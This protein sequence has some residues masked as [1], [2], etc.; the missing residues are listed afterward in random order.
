MRN[1]IRSELLINREDESKSLVSTIK[2]TN[3]TQV[4][5]LYST[6]GIGKSSLSA[7][8][9]N[10]LDLD[11]NFSVIRAK[12]LPQNSQVLA[13]EGA[14]MSLIFE[15][16]YNTFILKHKKD[17]K[18][19]YRK[20]LS[21]NYYI[22]HCKNEVVKQAIKETIFKQIYSDFSRSTALKLIFFYTF[23]RIFKIGEFNYIYYLNNNGQ[24][25]RVVKN[26]YLKYIFSKTKILFNIDNIQNI[27]SIS[28][29]Y[30]IDW[31]S[32]SK[33]QNST[34][35]LEYTISKSFSME[36]MM[37]LTEYFK[38]A[39][40][41]IIIQPIKKMDENHA[42]YALQKFTN[43][44]YSQ[45]FK[46]K[47]FSYFTKQSCGNIRKLFD[48]GINYSDEENQD[49]YDPTYENILS[50]NNDCKYILSIIIAFNGSID[51]TILMILLER[52]TEIM[53]DIPQ[54]LL[55][56]L[57]YEYKLVER[58]NNIIE[59]QHASIIDSWI[60]H[61]K[62]FLLFDGIAYRK[63]SDLL[64]EIMNNKMYEQLSSGQVFT[65]L[66]HLYIKNE[67][68]RIYEL[69]DVL[70]EQI[71]ESVSARNAW[72]ILEEL[73]RYT[74]NNLNDYANLYY[75]I[76]FIC[77]DCELFK[78]GFNC[79]Q[80]WEKNTNLNSNFLIFKCLFMLGLDKHSEC[81]QYIK[82]LDGMPESSPSFQLSLLLINIVNYRSLNQKEEC[83][84]ISNLIESEK[85]YSN[86]PEYGYY[87]RLKAIFLPRDKGLKTIN[88]SIKFFELNNQLLQSSKSRITVAFYYAII[89]ELDTAYNH[90]TLA[91]NNLPNKYI[92]QYMIL[93]NKSAIDLLAGR[94]GNEVWENLDRAELS[95]TMPFDHLSI[96]NNK[97]VWCLAN[98]D[99]NN[100]ELII[101]KI[102]R[103]FKFEEDKH[104]RSFMYYNMH[105][106]YKALGN[107]YLTQIYYD[108]A[109][110]IR[111]FCT[112]LNAR[113]EN[114]STPD[115]TNFLLS[116]PWHVC[117]VSYWRFDPLS[118]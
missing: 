16:A 103:Y 12:T 50:L 61:E 49:S 35:L 27:D 101:N 56:K 65:L 59:I 116:K 17:K 89:G 13:E 37:T 81:I 107:N 102:K 68:Y 99:F 115:G 66:I 110:E 48:F 54:N 45:Q 30:M 62:D 40:S 108:K 79:I 24:E 10:E 32:Y 43:K 77:Y 111:S 11:I 74:E 70:K 100:I 91:E 42:F 9:I 4:I 15:E 34:F 104:L 84:K 76:L 22:T 46:E 87:L 58:K 23:K 1:R 18:N 80:K 93:N 114:T 86:L 94:Y 112:T 96:Q 28:L 60:E 6:T 57:I 52:C 92:G 7:K 88:E 3:D 106:A 5:F 38:E 26:G 82:T 36:N 14:Y 117:F 78:E 83:Q 51:E 31:I 47:A 97:L 2:S 105:L 71:M 29:K 44:Q 95:A 69:I 85:E 53:S 118:N 73:L 21:F 98:S 75:K 41:S 113:F 67:P 72:T 39:G 8:V 109:Y 55:N 90:I 19:K 63:V 33:E 64:K 20:K 25:C